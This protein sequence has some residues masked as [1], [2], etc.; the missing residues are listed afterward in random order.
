M[1]REKKTKLELKSNTNVYCVSTETGTCG[2]EPRAAS[3]AVDTRLAPPG[4]TRMTPSLHDVHTNLQIELDAAK[5]VYVAVVTEKYPTR[6]IFSS[7]SGV[8]ASPRLMQELRDHVSALVAA[9]GGPAS[10]SSSISSP[11]SGKSLFKSKGLKTFLKTL[12]SKFDDVDGIDKIAAAARRVQDVQR[13]MADNINQASER[14][15]LLAGI[16]DKSK[17]LNQS[18]KSM[19]ESSTALKRK[20]CCR[21]WMAYTIVTSIFLFAAA[22]IILGLNYGQYHWWD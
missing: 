1:L 21:K 6:Y 16:D 12:A 3:D 2:L 22:A 15:G 18:A 9:N 7:S 20:S 5:R 4:L 8:S 17:K 13:I 14:D 10:G 19:F 11:E